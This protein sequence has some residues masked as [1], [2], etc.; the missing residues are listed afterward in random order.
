MLLGRR[1]I[2]RD[3]SVDGATCPWPIG[4]LSALSALA[5]RDGASHA[6][7]LDHGLSE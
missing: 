2:S 1:V 3:S 4:T 7:A 5:A 6:Y